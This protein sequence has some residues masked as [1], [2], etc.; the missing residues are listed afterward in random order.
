MA[1]KDPQVPCKMSSPGATLKWFHFQWAD[2][3]CLAQHYPLP[4]AGDT[5]AQRKN[6]NKYQ[7]SLVQ[8]QRKHMWVPSCLCPGQRPSQEGGS[9]LS[10]DL[11]SLAHIPFGMETS[12]LEV[13][14]P[15]TAPHP[16]EQEG[17]G[18]GRH[19]NEAEKDGRRLLS[20]SQGMDMR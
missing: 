11:H 14:I 9:E 8:Q 5:H 6:L 1:C 10:C 15:A 16:Q 20:T 12:H 3:L 7:A 4:F 19:F 2:S 17:G 13:L 18:K